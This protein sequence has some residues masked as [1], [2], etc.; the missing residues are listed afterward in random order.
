MLSEVEARRGER[1]GTLPETV[2][3]M[4]VLLAVMFGIIDFGRALYTY[5][6]VTN[7]ARQGARWAI[8]R[9]SK[10]TLLDHCPAAKGS[11]D[12][13][14]Y[15]QGLSE[16]A[17]TANNISASLSFPSCPSGVVSANGNSPGC[18]AEVTVQYPFK[19][20]LPFLPAGI[21]LSSTSEMVISN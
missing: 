20:M 12:I 6:F 21:Q 16:G 10:C 13:Q 7:A 1:G 9:G 3:V 5:S 2:I 14:P 17:M 8:V 4:S 15:V 19:F 11:T 18:V